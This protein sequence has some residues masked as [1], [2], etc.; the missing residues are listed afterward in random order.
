MTIKPG[1]LAPRLEQ[2]TLALGKTVHCHIRLMND[3]RWPWIILIPRLEIVTEFHELTAESRSALISQ[4][5]VTGSF[6][7]RELDSK[8]I[9][10]AMLGNV[11]T[12]LH[13]HVISRTEGDPCWPAPVWGFGEAVP[14]PDNTLPGFAKKLLSELNL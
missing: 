3:S 2:D 14:W 7:Q 13:C 5:T 4:A 11:V 12:Q 6:L 9:N 8:S 10:T 1:Q